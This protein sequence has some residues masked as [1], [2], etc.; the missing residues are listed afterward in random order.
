MH[1]AKTCKAAFYHLHN[2]RGIMEFLTMESTK[3]LVHAFTMG[4]INYCNSLLYGLATTNVNKLQCMHNATARLICST[5]HFS[6]VTT[7]LCSLRRLP[8]KFR[9]DLKI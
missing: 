9:I 1:I 7:M 2:I 5:L 8:V 3:V 6:G 4:S